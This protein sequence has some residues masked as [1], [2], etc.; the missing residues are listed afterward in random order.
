ME[1]EK[2]SVVVPIYNVEEYLPK[3]IESLLNQTYEDL[4]IILVD[5]GGKDNC[6]SICEAYAE[7]DNRIKVIHK[8]NG[9][10]SDARN[11]GT[12]VA[13]GAYI[14][15]VDSDDF[16]KSDM[17]EKMLARMRETN[18]DIAICNFRRVKVDGTPVEEGN[19][20]MS[21]EDR[22]YDSKEAV[23]HLCGENYEYWVTAWNRLYKA[24]IAKTVEFPKGKIHEDEFTAHLFYDKAEKIVGL[25]EPF[26]QYVIRENSIMTR[27]YSVK[28]LAYVEALNH[29]IHY[30]VKAD[31]IGIAQAF[32]RWMAKYLVKVEEDL[33]MKD[34][35]TKQRYKACRN[36]FWQT[37]GELSK[38]NKI[39]KKTKLA[40]IMLRMPKFIAKTVLK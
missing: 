14:A 21:V 30:C 4:E 5:D 16:I 17:Y 22:V 34:A 20:Y 40:A 35:E 7:K 18:A 19:Q 31:M 29:R 23:A 9:G 3:C 27:K 12:A 36:L 1:K 15:Y 37:Y 2:I 28:N 8:E 33:N 38:Q 32:L 26:Y 13:T 24:E 25:S 6:P 11:A 10:L 39:D